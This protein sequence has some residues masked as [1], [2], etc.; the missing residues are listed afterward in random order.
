MLDT[1][2]VKLDQALLIGVCGNT[3]THHD[4]WNLA[5]SELD[6]WYADMIDEAES[7]G[8]VLARICTFFEDRPV[9]FYL[10][11]DE[12]TVVDITDIEKS[13]LN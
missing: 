9:A 4:V 7:Y 12:V 11:D 6:K 13:F 1:L 2:K 5:F 3:I 8:I 10:N